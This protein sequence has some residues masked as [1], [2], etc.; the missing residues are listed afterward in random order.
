MGADLIFILID[1]TAGSACEAETWR[2]RPVIPR[3]DDEAVG[4][5]VVVTPSVAGVSPSV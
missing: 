4:R 5:D 3:V 2:V 1:L